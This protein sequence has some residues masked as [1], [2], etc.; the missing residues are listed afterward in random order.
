MYFLGKAFQIRG[1]VHGDEEKPFLEHLEE[2]RIMI[3]KIVV[4]LLIST[5]VC[6]IFHKDL[7]KVMSKPVHEVW[8]S[9]QETK[10][11]ENISIEGWEHIKE[12]QWAALKLKP[13][14]RQSFYDSFEEEGLQ[15]KAESAGY[16]ATALF[17]KS[18]DDPD[19]NSDGNKE[20]QKAWIDKLP[21]ISD[22]HCVLVHD[23]IE[24]G[25]AAEIDAKSKVVDM[26]SLKPTETFMLAFKLAFYAGLV[27]SFPLV[28]WF[29]L[30]FVLPGLRAKEKKVMWPA[31]IVGFGLFLTGA[32]F[33]YFIVL[34][35]ALDFFFTF[36]SDMGV[37]NEWRIGEYI[38]FVTQF[39]LV[40]GL[41]FELPV[42]VMA[43]VKMGLVGYQAMSNTRSYAV[44]A[45]VV[46]AAMITPTSDVLTLS[47]LAVPMYLLYEICIIFAYFDYRKAQREEKEEYE[48]TGVR[49]HPEVSSPAGLIEMDAA[50]DD[51]YAHDIDDYH[52]HEHDDYHDEHDAY[53]K[54]HG[55]EHSDHENDHDDPSGE[56]SPAD[57]FE[58]D[59]YAKYHD[60]EHY[61]SGDSNHP[62]ADEADGDEGDA[63][64]YDENVKEQSVEDKAETE[65]GVTETA[66]EDEP[67]VSDAEPAF[68]ADSDEDEH[69][70]GIDF[71]PGANFETEYGEPESDESEEGDSTDKKK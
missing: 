23:M 67:A 45:I 56:S 54:E 16:Y 34:P 50:E 26:K 40:F 3:T 15:L 30:Q 69:G 4:T 71:N 31:M 61:Y 25:P 59:E 33:A 70:D 58:H 5:I 8:N 13:E 2:L 37:Q 38:S 19:E 20:L 22:A 68:E 32:T 43:L 1:K 28:L 52:D 51:P 60:P 29:I 41:A 63:D 24:K 65:D 36:G 64:S 27:V 44:L 53:H 12:V 18:K 57:E 21:G 47:M 9:R 11:P 48:R 62:E 55:Y 14:E 17:I 7:I 35:R 42:I 49:V 46:I 39:T 6:W 10:L 66:A